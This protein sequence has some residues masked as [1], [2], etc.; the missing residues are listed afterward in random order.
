MS[1]VTQARI[2]ARIPAPKLVEALDDDEDGVLDADVLTE[3]LAAASEAVDA[4]IAPQYT[5]PR[6]TPE[7]MVKE[8]AFAFA[9]EMIY[10]RRG[11]NDKNP[12]RKAASEWRTKLGMVGEGK[13][14]LD[15]QAADSGS[16][17]PSFNDTPCHVAQRT[18]QD[19][20]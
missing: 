11:A 12:F 4:L 1:Y 14:T 13:L 6:T 3:L 20:L 18:N 8:G 17:G 9:C 7:A 5:V 10:D 15:A 19:G 16:G 2:E